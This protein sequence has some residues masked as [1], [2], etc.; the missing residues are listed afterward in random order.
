MASKLP[1]RL[2]AAS[3]RR[4]SISDRKVTTRAAGPHG[5]VAPSLRSSGGGGILGGEQ[6]VLHGEQ[7]GG[8]AVG[9]ADLHID[10]LDVVAGGL[11][12]DHQAR[13]DLFARQA[14]RE[15]PQDV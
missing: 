13:G 12:R 7:A 10:V 4:P 15:Q 14:T 2:M 6:A 11:R 5:A 9:D 3:I 1:R 8:R